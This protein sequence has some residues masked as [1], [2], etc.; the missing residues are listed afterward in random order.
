MKPWRIL[1]ILSLLAAAGSAAAAWWWWLQRPLPL[2]TPTVELSIEPG[3]SPHEVAQAW[4]RAGVMTDP[5]LLYQWF[6]L[7]GD[8]RRIRAGG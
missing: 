8:A 4:V 3:T 2:A 1:L 7:S 5:R 6:R